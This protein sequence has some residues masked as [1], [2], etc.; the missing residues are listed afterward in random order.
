MYIMHRIVNSLL[1]RTFMA[2]AQQ[3]GPGR[4]AGHPAGTQQALAFVLS[5]IY[6][7][8]AGGLYAGCGALPGP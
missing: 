4:S 3:R 2:D 1:G 7:G 8:L 5:V 6:A